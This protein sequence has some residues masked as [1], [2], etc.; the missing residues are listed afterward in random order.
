MP[1]KTE[2]QSGQR[3]RRSIRLK[4]YDYSQSGAYFVTI[5]THNR[6]QLF[7][8]VIGDEMLLNRLGRIVHQE[9]LRSSEIRA[10]VELGEFVVMPNHIH[11]VV[12]IRDDATTLAPGTG[13]V[14]GTAG[15]KRQPRSLGAFVAGFK[16]AT[17]KHINE[18]RQSPG[19]PV[20]QRNYYEH[21][22]RNDESLYEIEEYILNNPLNWAMDKENPSARGDK[23]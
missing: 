14:S 16:A 17:T 10:E 15:R 6:Q 7:G 13:S 18:S 8:S 19:T 20:W 9:W 5:C 23:P 3:H 11:G 1:H 12:I 21:I 2:H 22:V 4:G